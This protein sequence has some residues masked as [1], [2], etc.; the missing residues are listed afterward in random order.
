MKPYAVACAVLA[1]GASAFADVIMEAE[2]NDTMAEANFIGAFDI[3]G[4]S[5]LVDGA[6]LVGDV[7][8]FEFTTTDDTFLVA[9]TFGIPDSFSGDS[10]L[11]LFD[12]G[13]AEIVVDDDSGIGLF[14]AIEAFIPAGTYFLG[15]TGFPDF[16]FVGAH[17]EEFTY[18]LVVGAN[19]IPA[20]GVLAL[21]AMAGVLALRR[22]RD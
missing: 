22:R 5:V 8:F 14:S 3:P 13:G 7:D 9:A 1:V 19:V 6:I 21:P 17:D 11:G 15:V 2:P 18:K 4:G 20:P 10:I 12:A 16:D